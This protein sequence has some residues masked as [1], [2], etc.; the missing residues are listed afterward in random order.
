MVRLL[1]VQN[2]RL[3]IFKRYREALTI[4][5]AIHEQYGESDTLRNLAA[6]ERDRGHL[7]EALRHIEAAVDLEEALRARIT[8]PEL[9]STYVAAEQNNYELFI[10]VL[11]QLHAASP[12]GGHGAMAFQVSERARARVLLES[13][14]DAR[15]D[16]RQ[17]IDPALLAREQSVQG[18]LTGA[19]A[20]LSRSLARSSREDQ[21]ADTAQRLERLTADYQQ[22]QAEIRQ[23]SPRS[24]SVTQPQPLDA[25]EIQRSVFYRGMLQQRRRPAAAL[26]A[27]QIGMSH[28]SRWVSPYYW[29]GFVLQG[30]WR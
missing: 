8:S 13:L 17:G 18:Q 9:R 2:L 26:R 25:A 30:E 28:D 11:Q 29:A 3:I 10:D 4:R 6:V 21:S 22:L 20:Q 27:A 16:L 23:K 24:A 1:K 15:V 5:H 19:S 14:L 12:G 7:I